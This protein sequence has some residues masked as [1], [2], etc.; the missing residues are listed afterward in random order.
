MKK[1]L[2][3]FKR[4][5]ILLSVCSLLLGV[6]FLA[7]PRS[8][9]LI[10][11]YIC[12]GALLVA[13]I[14]NVVVYFR[15]EAE[16]SLFHQ[17]L[18]HGAV[19]LIAGAYIIASPEQLLAFLPFAMGLVLLYDSL[20]KFQSALDLQRLRWRYWWAMLLAGGVTAVLGLLMVFDPFAA[21]DVLTMFCGA[22]LVVNAIMDLA[23]V[24]CVTRR[25]KRVVTVVKREVCGIPVED[26]IILRERLETEEA[27]ALDEN[28]GEQS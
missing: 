9:G 21:A 3:D 4:K 23:A 16:E 5:L 26:Y 18:V 12:G 10:I 19:E 8:S 7:V 6:L 14:W 28:R 20:N 17:E 25:V 2:E 24:F 15:R 27:A 13:G 22:A 11:C 1:L